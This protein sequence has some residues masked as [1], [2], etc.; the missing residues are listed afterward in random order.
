MICTNC[1]NKSE[2][3]YYSKNIEPVLNTE[4]GQ[5]VN[6][7]YLFTLFKCLDGFT[8]DFYKQESEK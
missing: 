3:R 4:Q 1:Q 5:F 7:E 6:D 8:C 2:C